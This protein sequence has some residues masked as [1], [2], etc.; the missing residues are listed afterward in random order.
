M[1]LESD[2]SKGKELLHYKKLMQ[3]SKPQITASNCLGS[4]KVDGLES[5]LAINNKT[6]CMLMYPFKIRK[7]TEH[8]YG[9]RVWVLYKKKQI[10]YLLSL[11]VES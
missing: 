9:V 10:F 4:Q 7:K 5:K 1:Y 6:D 2:S 8:K 3:T 11:T